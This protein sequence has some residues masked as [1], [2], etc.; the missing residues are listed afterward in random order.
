MAY[1]PLKIYLCFV[2]ISDMCSVY[3]FNTF[4]GYGMRNRYK[5]FYSL[6]LYLPIP[7]LF[8]EQ[9][10]LP[11][12][13]HQILHFLMSL[14]LYFS[15]CSSVWCCDW[16]FHLWYL[17]RLLLNLTGKANSPLWFF[18]RMYIFT[19]SRLTLGAFFF[20]LKKL[21]WDCHWHY[22]KLTKL[23][24][25]SGTSTHYWKKI[26]WLLNIEWTVAISQ[27]YMEYELVGFVVFSVLWGGGGGIVVIIEIMARFV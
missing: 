2:C 19:L 17:Y 23:T 3:Y 5:R 9:I 20:Q 26:L 4:F 21:T 16:T 11:S 25:L 27:V 22:V 13:L 14:F 12:M 7:T 18:F 24:W 10:S 8:Y 6:N 1:I 15:F